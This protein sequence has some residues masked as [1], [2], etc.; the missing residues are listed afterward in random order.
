[1]FAGL[2]SKEHP[3]STWGDADKIMAALAPYSLDKPRDIWVTERQMLLQVATRNDAISAGIYRHPESGVAVAFWG[4]LD[5]RPELM[6]LLDAEL[7]AS[8][9]ELIALAWLKWGEH[10]PERL[11][12]DFSFAVQSVKTGVVFLVRDVMGVKPM[13]YRA[14][15]NGVFF[16]NTAAAFKP[17]ALG[18]LTRSRKWMAEYM[19]GLS[20]HH[21]E[22]A[23][24]EIKKLP[25]AHSLLVAADGRMKLRRYHQFA[26]DA[27]VERKRDPKYLEAYRA[28]WQEAV[29]CRMPS[30][31]NIGTEN[32]GG[33]DSGSVTAE[34][35]RQLGCDK[36]RL[37][38]FAYC[39][40]PEEP[41]C[42][43]ATPMKY[44]LDHQFIVAD[45]NENDY[46]KMQ[47]REVDVSGYPH[48]QGVA[49]AHRPFYEICSRFEIASLF[50]GFGGDE[51]V[52]NEFPI[53]FE[54]AQNRDFM[55]LVKLM[56]GSCFR[57]IRSAVGLIKRKYQPPRFD[58]CQ[59]KAYT[60]R[61]KYYF[62][63]KKELHEFHLHESY[64][65]QSRFLFPSPRINDAALVL[66]NQPYHSTRFENCSLIASSYG[67]EYL[68][69]MWDQRLVQQWLSTP[70]IWKMGNNA[71]PR[72]LH[73]K[74]V[75]EVCP[76]SITWKASKD[77]GFHQIK[78]RL[79]NK[80][81]KPILVEL[82]GLLQTLEVEVESILDKSM[83]HALIQNSMDCDVK[84]ME[85]YFS[86][87]ATLEALSDLDNWH[88][89]DA[90]HG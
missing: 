61:W 24:E 78:D 32:S 70:S 31:G 76:D 46:K 65:N 73:R 68:W 36:G 34:L 22:T 19:L 77:M 89:H 83:A 53:S 21:N 35:A 60:E 42:I 13:Y 63:N 28:V 27:P 29:S 18:N 51:V 1:M 8:D 55:N 81:L 4:R 37:Y 45:P 14:D 38:G 85:A 25:G 43:M 23:Y 33:L 44:H 62:I 69:P 50:S 87:Q 66:I 40:E 41:A 39:L 54:L 2:I 47:K 16:A 67:I 71:L 58:D 3:V 48:E 90:S 59:L 9:D 64:I 17:L 74:A 57:K 12:G 11:V 79:S 49:A 84:G 80:N 26:D 15:A 30:S 86:F 82:K 56:P 88:K 10:S 75:D 7:E 5:N 6:M 52:T 20:C 72:F